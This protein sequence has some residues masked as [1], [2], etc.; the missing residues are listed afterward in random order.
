MVM[1]EQQKLI[2][3]YVR[4]LAKVVDVR[5][6]LEGQLEEARKEIT[7]TGDETKIAQLSNRIVELQTEIDNINAL[8]RSY[9]EKIEK[10]SGVK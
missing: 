7:M 3:D 4:D 10:I 9:I 1:P 2:N 5:E 8:G 6:N